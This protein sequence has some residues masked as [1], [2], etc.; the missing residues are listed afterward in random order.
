[1]DQGAEGNQSQPQAASEDT[2][3]ENYEVMDSAE[4][5]NGTSQG[6]EAAGE[7]YMAMEDEPQ[8]QED[9][10]EPQQEKTD[11]QNYEIADSNIKQPSA[12]QNE[13]YETPGADSDYEGIK[14]HQPF[15]NNN[16]VFG[17]D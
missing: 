8:V 17:E 2:A 1:M 7:D 6:G 5:T 3:G 15:F 9:Y 13:E 10:E 16:C 4:Q 14:Q 11:D 12:P